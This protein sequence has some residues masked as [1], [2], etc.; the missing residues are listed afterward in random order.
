L[1]QGIPTNRDSLDRGEKDPEA[2]SH[3]WLGVGNGFLGLG[4]MDS[5]WSKGTAEWGRESKPRRELIPF[6]TKFLPISNHLSIDSIK[7][8][9]YND[10][11]VLQLSKK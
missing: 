1:T 6:L 7:N 3:A 11:M 2:D 8:L 10:T 9:G 4:A 5:P